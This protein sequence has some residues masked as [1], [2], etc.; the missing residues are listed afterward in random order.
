MSRSL[1]PAIRLRKAPMLKGLSFSRRAVF[2]LPK[3]SGCCLY[4]SMRKNR[5]KGDYDFTEAD[6][7]GPYS[8][9]R[10]AMPENT[11]LRS[12]MS[13]SVSLWRVRVVQ[14]EDNDQLPLQPYIQSIDMPPRQPRSSNVSASLSDNSELR[15]TRV[16]RALLPWREKGC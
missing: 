12:P 3:K 2:S 6:M 4:L 5:P 11:T 1:W 7:R 8:A 13:A 14:R 15:P 16:R 10:E 9:L